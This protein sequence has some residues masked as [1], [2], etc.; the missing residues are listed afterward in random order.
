[1]G[2][3]DPPDM[4]RPLPEIYSGLVAATQTKILPD[5][6]ALDSRIGRINFMYAP[7]DEVIE[8]LDEMGQ[9]Q[10]GQYEKYLTVVL[11]EDITIRAGLESGY[12]E[13]RVNMIIFIKTEAKYKSWQ[14]EQITFPILRLVRRELFRQMKLSPHF[15]NELPYFP[16]E[17]TE[18][19]RWG[20]QKLIGSDGKVMGDH[21]DAIEIANLEL[22]LRTAE[23][24]APVNW[25]NF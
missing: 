12:F 3:F 22:K 8:V 16:C 20:R 25:K 9:S 24:A 4:P 23:G 7:D 17:I 2:Q 21:I 14:R 11:F 19:K 5:L 13:T 10:A 1:M 18:R 6:Q 15:A